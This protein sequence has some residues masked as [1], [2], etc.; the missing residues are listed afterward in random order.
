MI[1]DAGSYKIVFGD[2]SEHILSCSGAAGTCPGPPTVEHTY[3]ANGNYTATL[4]QYGYFAPPSDTQEVP[5]RTLGVA[6]IHVGDKSVCNEAKPVCGSKPI[7]CITTPCDPVQQTYRN[8]CELFAD[9]ASFLHEGECSSAG[10]TNKPPVISGFTGPTTLKVDEVG[11][12]SVNASDPE[13]AALSY[14]ILW[15]DE[16]PEHILS[17]VA[18]PDTAFTQTSSFT[19]AYNSPGVYTV[20]VTVRDPEGKEARMAT[21][22]KVGGEFIACTL[23]YN[24]VCGQPPEPAC[25]NAEPACMVPTPAPKTYSNTCFLN[26]AGATLLY[27]GQCKDAIAQPAP[28]PDNP[29]LKKRICPLLTIKRDLRMAEGAEGDDVL[30]LQEFLHALGFLTVAPTGYFGPLT[31]N[32]LL[33]W[34]RLIPA[35]T[36]PNTQGSWLTPE[37]I[38]AWGRLFPKQGKYLPDPLTPE[39]IRLLS[40]LVPHNICGI[41]LCPATFINP[42]TYDEQM[43]EHIRTWCEGYT[44][45]PVEAPPVI[46]TMDAKQCPDG[47]YV[48]RTGPNCAFVCPDIEATDIH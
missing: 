4:V 2:T 24:P 39:Q 34:Q 16:R 11:T 26:A 1:A 18:S 36:Y 19:H 20:M 45:P 29:E 32:A 43:I 38:R 8:R 41:G 47:S 28:L 48:G 15:G 13:N 42:T 22:V 5:Q 6:V 7:V 40:Y 31:N 3:L 44:V 9:N 17:A 25:R 10:A 46:C 27:G 37:Q 30:A 12:W 35:T 21:T 23:E 33:Q 14:R